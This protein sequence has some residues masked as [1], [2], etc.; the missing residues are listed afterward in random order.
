MVPVVVGALRAHEGVLAIEQPELHLH[1]AIQVGMGDL[2]I[3]AVRPDPDRV[4][5]SKSLIIET[6]SEHIMLRLLRRIRETTE[7]ELPPGVAGLNTDDL[8]VIYFESGDEGVR[9]HSLAI[10]QHGEFQNRWPHGFFE[11]RAAELF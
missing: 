6:H 10:D 3:R 9:F 11:E 2:F 4:P 7:G 5:P 1:P 8:S